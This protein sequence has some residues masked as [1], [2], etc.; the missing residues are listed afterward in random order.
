[1]FIYIKLQKSINIYVDILRN[2]WNKKI[3]HEIKTLACGAMFALTQAG[4]AL[5]ADGNSTSSGFTITS[6]FTTLLEGT[7]NTLQEGMQYAF[8]NIS[9]AAWGAVGLAVL[10]LVIKSGLS[11][12]TGEGNPADQA[13]YEN[14]IIWSVRVLAVAILAFGVIYMLHQKFA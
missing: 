2:M 13:K 11:H 4:T 14:A 8:D 1:M 10:I 12:V 7:S 9:S 6:A 3:K 5:A